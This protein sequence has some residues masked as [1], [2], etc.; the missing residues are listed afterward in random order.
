MR[1]KKIKYDTKEVTLI[2]T[3][4]TSGETHEHTITSKAHPH[5]DFVEALAALV[6]DVVDICGLPLAYEEGLRVQS[7]TFS[8]SEKTGSSGAVVTALKSLAMS[9]APLVLNTPH[10]V[11]DGEAGVM[12]SHMRTRLR[13]LESEAQQ[14]LSGKRAQGDLFDTTADEET[15]AAAGI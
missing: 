9:S 6:D 5:P 15:A 11:E 10:L 1:F 7:V 2:F 14:Y 13:G 3:T 8:Y 4:E 12:T